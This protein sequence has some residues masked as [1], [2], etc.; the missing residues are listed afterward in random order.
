MY[1]SYRLSIALS[2]TV[3]IMIIFFLRAFIR[4]SCA[5]L[6]VEH[7]SLKT[8]STHARIMR[9]FRENDNEVRSAREMLASLLWFLDHNTG[10]RGESE[11]HGS[12]QS[13][14][15]NPR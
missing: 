6:T 11:V 15:T 4:P 3:V 7:I 13:S 8:L 9:N 12:M 10:K 2:D 14:K 5:Y 1:A